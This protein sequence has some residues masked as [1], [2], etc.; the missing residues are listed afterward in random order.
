[1]Y[2]LPFEAA[3]LFIIEKYHRTLGVESTGIYFMKIILAICSLIFLLSTFSYIRNC[4]KLIPMLQGNYKFLPLLIFKSCFALAYILVP[5]I[6]TPNLDNHDEWEQT[7]FELNFVMGA[8]N[9]I[10]TLFVSKFYK[11]FSTEQFES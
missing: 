7:A 8:A 11:P 6:N 9:F 1:M 3:F 2:Y 10:L 4:H 5:L